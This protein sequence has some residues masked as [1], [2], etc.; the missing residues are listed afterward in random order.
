MTLSSLCSKCSKKD[1]VSCVGYLD[2]ILSPSTLLGNQNLADKIQQNSENI[3]ADVSLALSFRCTWIKGHFSGFLWS[4]LGWN[5]FPSEGKPR[6][7][8]SCKALG[9]SFWMLQWYPYLQ[10]YLTPAPGRWVCYPSVGITD[11][12]PPS[13]P[14]LIDIF[15]KNKIAR[16][17]VGKMFQPTH[18]SQPLLKL[19]I[20]MMNPRLLEPNPIPE[21]E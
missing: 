10:F 3:P 8:E 4:P 13:P 7:E 1:S 6:F 14:K 2:S 5:C 17:K 9:W 18:M 20:F 21:S 11:P 16:V 12:P 15:R 19:P